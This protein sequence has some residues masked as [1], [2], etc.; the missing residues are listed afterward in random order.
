V[1]IVP[2]RSARCLTP[3]SIVVHVDDS[4]FD[5]AVIARGIEEAR[6]RKAPLHV[7]TTWREGST[8]WPLDAAI[9][10]GGRR[11]Q[12]QLTRRLA[13]WTRNN[14]DVE[15]HAVAFHGTLLN[16]VAKQRDPAQLVIARTGNGIGARELFEPRA[17]AALHDADC[18]MLVVGS[19]H[20]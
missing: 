2:G 18:S 13:C 14:P 9:A 6:L 3:G 15:I 1:A 10:D 12:A 5:T 20:L 11:V 7:V 19:Q 17:H 8:D 16:Y 4:P